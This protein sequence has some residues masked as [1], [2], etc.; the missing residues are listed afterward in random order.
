MKYYRLDPEVAGELGKHTVM[1]TSIHPPRV[2]RLHYEL[3]AWLGDD[4]IQTFPCYLVTE[5]LKACLVAESLTGIEFAPVVFTLSDSF[6][7]LHPATAVPAFV[8]LK[9][10]GVAGKDDFGT[11]QDGCLIVSTMAL[12]A[13]KTC[14]L[15]HCDIVEK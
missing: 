15:N 3:D 6:K 5:R 12:T 8:W 13:I 4:L 9:A 1:D 7:E 14:S 2:S 10:I 11:E